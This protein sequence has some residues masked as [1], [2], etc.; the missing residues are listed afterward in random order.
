MISISGF[1]FLMKFDSK[2]K[3]CCVQ[4]EQ[5]VAA[6]HVVDY[7][8]CNIEQVVDSYVQLYFNIVLCIKSKSGRFKF[9]LYA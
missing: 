7:A 6:A 5:K 9:Q 8:N 2:N 4:C 3:A 1:F